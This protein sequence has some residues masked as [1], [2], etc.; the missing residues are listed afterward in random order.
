[1]QLSNAKCYATR[2]VVGGGFLFSN[3]NAKKTCG[4]SRT[5]DVN[6]AALEKAELTP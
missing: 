2:Q 5:F 1:L 4:C 6:E 3:P